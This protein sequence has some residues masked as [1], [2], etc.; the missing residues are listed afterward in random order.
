MGDVLSVVT[1][2]TLGADLQPHDQGVVDGLVHGPVILP[3]PVHHISVDL[4]VDK[5]CVVLGAQVTLLNG[6]N[7]NRATAVCPWMEGMED[8]E[9][10]LGILQNLLPFNHKWQKTTSR[11]DRP[12]TQGLCF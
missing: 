8:G 5:G 9:M 1:A 10:G 12:L 4:R 3:D 2:H 7:W 11:P 6:T